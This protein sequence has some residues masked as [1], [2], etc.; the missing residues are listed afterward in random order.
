MKQK[1]VN[2]FWLLLMAWRDSRRNLGRLF[3][4]VSSIILGIAAL[5]AVYSL[6]DNVQEEMDANAAS[7]IGA[8]I[9][10]S[11][12]KKISD[13]AQ[14][15]IDSLGDRR[16]EERSFASMVFFPKSGGTRLA[17]IRALQ[18]DFP[19]Y[20]AL[21]T[22]PASAGVTFRNNQQ[23]LV[24]QTLMLQYNVK[25]GDSV[26]VGN[27]TF[28]I[29][30]V[31]LSTPGRAAFSTSISPPVFIPLKYLEE[32]GLSQKGSRIDYD[33]Y[34]KWDRKVD[35]ERIVQQL[36]PR[37][38]AAGI[39]VETVESERED[40][41]RSLKDMARFLS[42]IGFIAL[43]LGCVGVASAINIYIRE[44]INSIAVLRCLGAKSY[45]AFLIYLM[46]ILAIGLIGSVIGAALGV[47]IQQ[48]LPGVVKQFLP[49]KFGT[50][51]SW[52]SIGR[53]VLLG[54]IISF[55]FGLLPLVSIR[56]ISP[57]NT[58]RLS[59][60]NEKLKDPLKWL[61]YLLILGFVLG[62]TYLQM[63][64]FTR[65][66]FFTG[67]VI[68]AFLILSGIALLLM[69]VVRKIVKGTMS[70]M[71]RQGMS[72]LHRPNNQTTILVT[73][74]GL[75]TSLIC[76]IFLIQNLLLN[77]ISLSSSKNQPNLILFDIQTKQKDSLYAIA[78]QQSVPVNESVPIVNMRLES[79]NDLKAS[80]YVNDTSESISRFL[81]SR[82]Y[83]VTFRDTLTTSESIVKGKFSGTTNPGQTPRISLEEGFA[84]RNNIDIG[85]TMVFNVQGAIIP[86]IV[87]SH[88][89]VDW[90]RLQ[91]NF[92][93]V[94]PTGVLEDA[95]Q[96]HVLL[97]QVNS[98]EASAKF[99]QAV[100]ANFPNVSIIDIGLALRLLEDILG[101]ISVV[102]Q[103]I[104]GFSILTG[105]VVLIASVLISRY[106]RMQESVLLR[107]L[108]A[109]SKQI[110]TITALE[111]F[112]L[113]AFAALTGIIL[114]VGASWA[115]AK[116]LFEAPFEV[117]F[118]PLILVFFGV[119]TLTMMIG[120]LNSRAVLTKP[121]L[122]I[123]RRE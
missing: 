74:I 78:K 114:A 62:F 75:G 7:L 43:L 60:Q 15:M 90:N 29:A 117:N 31:L 33:Y 9:E 21:E 40:A 109:K 61:V 66:A 65:S 20:G 73:A 94:F 81:F 98:T 103:F 85:D 58:L 26:R 57:L 111:Y 18:G 42:L 22:Q 35:V 77:R 70:Y 110:F 54:V 14:R 121:P 104:A 51:L 45:Q 59:F 89:E 25:V 23:G 2:F 44:K 80:G 27:V 38:D 82:E 37:T 67:G 52:P 19:Y 108:G 112:L 71:W 6:S 92:I 96:F 64:N 36:K 34:I 86:T 115:L 8:D 99:Q 68:V 122:E 120:M 5:V 123:L 119:C 107:T 3:L 4:F 50:A 69:W 17:R 28:E 49:I 84:N 55:L 93:V 118:F 72:N 47:V 91:T 12:N 79:L 30:G 63:D 10:F 13:R 87:G 32:T 56:K 16:S 105:L 39:W 46:Q 88:R 11:S 24:D 41:A 76:I 116:F 97:T 48:M 113:G 100:V 102:V 101:Q 1:K 106:Q 83:R 95:P 53:G